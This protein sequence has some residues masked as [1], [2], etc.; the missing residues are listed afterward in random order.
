[1]QSLRSNAF[2]AE[3]AGDD[4]P[5]LSAYINDT[6]HIL[7]LTILRMHRSFPVRA[8]KPLRAKQTAFFENALGNPATMGPIITIVRM[9]LFMVA[10]AVVC[11]WG[12]VAAAA[13]A[14]AT[15]AAAL[16]GV[17]PAANQQGDDKPTTAEDALWS[18]LD[19]HGA[20]FSFQPGYSASG[21]R[22]GYATKD[23]PASGT[24]RD[25]WLCWGCGCAPDKNNRV[26]RCT[27]VELLVWAV[28]GRCV[29]GSSGQTQFRQHCAYL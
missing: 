3:R 13:V 29:F 17:A 2:R 21:V 25:E 12:C 6:F 23:L 24:V 27:A 28:D 7:P 22:G 11:P 15:T 1:M 9:T 18:W 10:L 4:A 26:I 5:S 14:P 19:E 8:A 16:V 20:K